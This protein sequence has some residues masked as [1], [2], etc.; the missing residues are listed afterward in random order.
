[1]IK[2]DMRAAATD[3]TLVMSLAHVTGFAHACKRCPNAE[4]FDTLSEYYD[5]ADRFAAV[6]G[7]H[8][9]KCMGDGVLFAFPEG[10]ARS[11][12]SALEEFRSVAS[13]LW[14]DFDP[15]CDVEI[16]VHVGHVT[17]GHFG[18]GVERH[19]DIVGKAVN[20]LF[21]MPWEGLHLSAELSVL[22][23]YSWGRA[24]S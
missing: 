19:F 2:R 6:V 10:A 12:I 17:A 24:Q 21:K 11:A 13:E 23:M 8:V 20:D 7:G 16:N 9:V 1:M 22:L 14:W 4:V 15:A 18:Q 5:V 3:Q